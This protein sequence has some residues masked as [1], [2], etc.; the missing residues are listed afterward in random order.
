MA[1]S[2]AENRKKY[3]HVPRMG[4]SVDEL[5]ASVNCSRSFVEKEWREGRGP[6]VTR[7][8][9]AHRVTPENAAIWLESLS[10]K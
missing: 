7:F 10:S 6:R 8:G 5:C 2:R 9:R 1:R 3:P 4:F